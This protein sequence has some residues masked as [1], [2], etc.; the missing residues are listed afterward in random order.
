MPGC[1]ILAFSHKKEDG[2]KEKTT[3]TGSKKDE[4]LKIKFVLMN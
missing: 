3:K 1:E 2:T 4:M